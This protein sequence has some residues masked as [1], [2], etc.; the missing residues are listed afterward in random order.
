MSDWRNSGKN[1]NGRWINCD[2]LF[3]I[4]PGRHSLFPHVSRFLLFHLGGTLVRPLGKSNTPS[5]DCPECLAKDS[6]LFDGGDGTYEF[7]HCI[8]CEAK[9]D[10]E[11]MLA[12]REKRKWEE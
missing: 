8:K 4:T 12:I 10:E 2:S 3:S 6:L 5:G 1:S 9:L 11:D 7:W